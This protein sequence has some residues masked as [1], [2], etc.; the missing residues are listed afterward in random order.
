MGGLQIQLPGSKPLWTVLGDAMLNTAIL[1]A[2]EIMSGPKSTL[3]IFMLQIGFKWCRIH[4]LFMFDS[5][6]LQL[7]VNAK[8]R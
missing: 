7:S 8:V 4:L 6:P 2:F 1:M 5:G 3:R